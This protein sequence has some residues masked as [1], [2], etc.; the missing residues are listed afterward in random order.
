ML[1]T[2]INHM[3]AEASKK[4]PLASVRT[5]RDAFI[6]VCGERRKMRVSSTQNGVFTPWRKLRRST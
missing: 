4:H 2:C 6:G 3:C 5:K 1:R